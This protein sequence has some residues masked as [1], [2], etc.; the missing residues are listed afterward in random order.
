MLI[1]SIVA[2]FLVA[3]YGGLIV[4]YHR[5]WD[6]MPLYVP[7]VAHDMTGGSGGPAGEAGKVRITVLVPARNEEV[8]IGHCLT[9][10]EGQTYPKEWWEVIV[11]DDHSTDGTAG[12]VKAA[13]S[14][15]KA[16][17]SGDGK[18]TELRLRYLSLAE[19]NDGS[20]L[21]AHKERAIEAGVQ[22]A[23]GE[24]IVTTDADCVFH[25]DWLKT[26]AAFY[27]EKG[28]KL[29]AAP[30]RIGGAM[31]GSA[32]LL[33][34]FQTLDFIVLQGITGAAVSKRVMSMCNGAN[35]IY[36]KKAFFEV[37][38]FSGIDAIPSGDDM[39]LMHKIYQRYP[40]GI[41]FLKNRQVVV[42]TR[43]EERWGDFI[44][45]RVRWASK[46]DRYDDTRIFWV[47]LLVYL[48]NVLFAVLLVAAFWNLWW[49]WVLLVLLVVKTI[50]EYPFVGSVAGF[51]G[52]RRL[53]VYFPFLQPMHI[54][55]TI[56]I[57]WLGRFGHYRWKDRKIA[58]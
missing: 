6:S 16:V 42:S 11:I 20:T 40:E 15:D 55:Y 51:F 3:F 12:I 50:V 35:L 22:E 56:V 7:A 44:H 29:I 49:L 53:M 23:K 34:I 25:P 31:S 48:V 26:I 58:V 57:G 2:I 30:V 52:Q 8:N 24:L 27:K 10:L 32:R 36:E 41:F 14:G 1:F 28:A 21:R 4:Y 33:T 37:G 54:I 19:R 13:A 45:Q 38:G 9:S 46:A 18:T 43:P 39:L 47:L 5:A 17:R